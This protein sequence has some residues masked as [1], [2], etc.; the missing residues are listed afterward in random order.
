VAELE[1]DEYSDF[2]KKSR[3][4]L[5]QIR[6]PSRPTWAKDRKSSG[7]K[8]SGKKSGEDSIDFEISKGTVS[9]H[10][11][12]EMRRSI[13]SQEECEKADFE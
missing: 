6:S 7:K 10:K 2:D 5:N 11:R 13:Q 12:D 3:S 1:Q 8:T 9:S 4:S